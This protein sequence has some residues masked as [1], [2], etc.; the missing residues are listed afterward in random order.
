MTKNNSV[1]TAAILN[2]KTDKRENIGYIRYI[3]AVHKSNRKDCHLKMANIFSLVV[4]LLA[5]AQV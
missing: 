3:F 5:V 2:L 1:C 4:T